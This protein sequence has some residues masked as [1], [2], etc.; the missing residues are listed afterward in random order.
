MR[1]VQ[2]VFEHHS[3]KQIDFMELLQSVVSLRNELGQ[4][5]QKYRNVL[6]RAQ[7][8]KFFVAGGRISCNPVDWLA[9][10]GAKGVLRHVFTCSSGRIFERKA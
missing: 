2:F 3:S 1:V 8:G 4:S 6:G 9:T 5:Q 10:I 7:L